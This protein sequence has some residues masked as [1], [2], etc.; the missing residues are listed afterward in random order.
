LWLTQ[1]KAFCKSQ[2]GGEVV[3]LTHQLSFTPQEDSC[4]SFLLEAESALVRTIQST[5]KSSDLIGKRTRHLPACSI[6]SSSHA[7]V[8][9]LTHLLTEMS[10]RNVPGVKGQ[11][12]CK[13]DNLAAICELS[14]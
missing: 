10:T 2:N 7:L 5:E 8:L 6:E 13:T 12:A 3:S 4:Y 11:P 9:M 1:S 14:V